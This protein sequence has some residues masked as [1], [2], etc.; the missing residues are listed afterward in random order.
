VGDVWT[1]LRDKQIF[2]KAR[3][4]FVVGEFV[5]AIIG[6]SAWRENFPVLY[7][8]WAQAAYNSMT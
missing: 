8:L 5:A 4:G 3:D 1:V 7:P 6:F 2:A